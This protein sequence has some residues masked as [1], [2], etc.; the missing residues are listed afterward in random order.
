MTPE[1]LRDFVAT[2]LDADKAFD[3]RTLDLRGVTSLTDYMIVASGQSTRQVAAMA[4][5]LRDRLEAAGLEDIRVEGLESGNWVV[6]DAGDV[7]VHL[8]RPE[9]RAFYN[10][11]KMWQTPHPVYPVPPTAVQA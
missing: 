4:Q 11:E 2:S 5:K 7:M 6:V 8:F 1:T 9:V 3:I 10:I